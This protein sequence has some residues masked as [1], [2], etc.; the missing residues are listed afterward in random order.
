MGD[1]EAWAALYARYWD[2][3]FRLANHFLRDRERARELAQEAFLRAIPRLQGL[4]DDRVFGP[5]LCRVA[6]NRALD[7]LRRQ[8]VERKR[9]GLER[10]MGDAEQVQDPIAQ[11]KVEGNQEAERVKACV[12][13]LPETLQAPFRLRVEAGLSAEEIAAVLGIKIPAAQKRLSRA[14]DLVKKCLSRPT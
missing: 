3:L 2:R 5:W 10:P 14:R 11:S 7:E 12:A 9:L 8:S 1:E 13:E 4:R 6:M